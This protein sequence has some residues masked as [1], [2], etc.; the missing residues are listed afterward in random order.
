MHIPKNDKLDLKFK[1]DWLVE[2]KAFSISILS[3]TLRCD[4]GPLEY[5]NG[6][7]GGDL[8]IQSFCI[9]FPASHS[10]ILNPHKTRVEY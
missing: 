10:Y 2:L 3:I 6:M 7:V 5:N 1:V 9:A 8:E 4:V